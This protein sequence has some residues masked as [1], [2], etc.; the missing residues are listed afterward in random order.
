MDSSYTWCNSTR[1]T[2]FLSHRF[3]KDQI[4]KKEDIFIYYIN[5]YL[6]T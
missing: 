1:V 2:P 5:K 4:V 3:L 6:P